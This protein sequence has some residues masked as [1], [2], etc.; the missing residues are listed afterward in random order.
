TYQL[1]RS[2]SSDSG[3][4]VSFDMSASPHPLSGSARASLEEV[5]KL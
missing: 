1:L 4:D 5:S 3:P 2:S